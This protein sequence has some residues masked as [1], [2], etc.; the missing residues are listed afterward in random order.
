VHQIKQK[1]VVRDG[2]IVIGDVM[3]LSLSFDHRVVDGHVGA[4]FAYDIIGARAATSG[5][6]SPR[7]RNFALVLSIQPLLRD[8]SSHHFGPPFDCARESRQGSAPMFR[9]TARV[10]VLAASLLA[11]LPAAADDAPIP[12]R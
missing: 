6:R 10:A 11:V 2:Q 9:A 5:N 4:A 12:R 8:N 3:L 7:G 1:P